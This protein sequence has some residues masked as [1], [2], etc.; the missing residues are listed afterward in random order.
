MHLTSPLQHTFQ[1]LEGHERIDSDFAAT[2]HDQAEKFVRE[3]GDLKQAMSV[4]YGD[5]ESSRRAAGGGDA[6]PI[7]IQELGDLGGL[8]RIQE[9]A[10]EVE[11]EVR[12]V[13]REFKVSRD[14]HQSISCAYLCLHC[15][16]G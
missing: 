13:T 11:T 6:A 3:I 10:F 15:L 12:R 7:M 5:W 4:V 9:E 1:A 2:I 16:F 8:R 14:R